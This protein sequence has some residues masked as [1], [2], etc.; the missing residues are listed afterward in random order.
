M[1]SLAV[2]FYILVGLFAIIGSTRGRTKEF[3]VSLS[4]LV[5]IFLNTILEQFVPG[6]KEFLT[7]D[8]A[9]VLFYVRA[10]IVFVI[11]ILGYLTPKLP[12]ISSTRIQLAN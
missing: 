8:S 11:V 6:Y 4:A 12:Q 10:G 3:L 5:A 9:S 2:L 7:R 1:V